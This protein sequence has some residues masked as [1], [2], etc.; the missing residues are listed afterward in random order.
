M[1]AVVKE[2]LLLHLVLPLADILMGTRISFWLKKI[3]TLNTYTAEQI[4]AWQHSLFLDYVSHIKTNSVYYNN[5]FKKHGISFDDIKTIEDLKQIPAIDKNIIREHFDEIVPLNIKKIKHRKGRTGGTTGMPLHYFFEED[6]WGYITAAKIYAWRTVGYKYGERFIT[7]GSSSLFPSGK[8]SW[9]NKMYFFLRNNI[10]LNGMNISDQVAA[11]YVEIIKKKKVKYLYGYAASIY[12][13]TDYIRRN[14]IDMTQIKAVFTTSEILL[15]EYRKIMEETYK[16]RVMDCYGAR[17][18]GITAYEIER[19][20]YHLSYNVIA[21]LERINEDGTGTLLLT[22][23]LNKAFPLINYR[24]GDDVKIEED[25]LKYNNKLITKLVG[26]TSDVMRF[27]NGHSLTAT[28][29]SI[30]IRDFN[31]KAF[32]MKKV[33]GLEILVQIEPKPAFDI[34]EKQLLY[35]TMKKHVGEEVKVVIEKVDKFEPLK[36]GKRRYFIN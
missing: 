27:D 28:G 8:M 15:P 21:Q 5:L 18:G 17:D 16:C 34:K 7:I 12:L 32:S 13:L 6:T 14:N 30:M 35:D 22:N 23:L 25:F 1:I 2:W 33:T 19:G 24:I 36:N 26:R 31:V 4:K 3:E 10:P 20:G 9:K 29:F 11:K